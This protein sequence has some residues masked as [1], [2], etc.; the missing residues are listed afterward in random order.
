MIA[1]GRRGLGGVIAA[2]AR[3]AAAQIGMPGEGAFVE[4]RLA[5]QISIAPQARQTEVLNVA[6]NV[7]TYYGPDKVSIRIVAFAGGIEL[8]RIGNKETP[9]IAAL[10]KQ[11][12]HFDA[13]QNTMDAIQRKTGKP[14]PRNPLSHPVPAGVVQLITLS[15]HGYTI[16]RP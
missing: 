5:L 4:H 15:E 8:L 16:I 12:V 2:A 14:F 9:R 13:C 1:I 11:G 10:V 7:L 6:Y 3:P